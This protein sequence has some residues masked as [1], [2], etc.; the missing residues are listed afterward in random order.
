[1]VCSDVGADITVMGGRPL[2]PGGLLHFTLTAGGTGLMTPAMTN[3]P[4]IAI[5]RRRR[6]IAVWAVVRV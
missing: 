4:T 2:P 6:A 1:M 5:A 3:G